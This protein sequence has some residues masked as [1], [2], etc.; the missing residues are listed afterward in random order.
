MI[1]VTK[2]D[3]FYT[4]S[5]VHSQ[6]SQDAIKDAVC[7]SIKGATASDKFPRQNIVPISGEMALYAR[8]LSCG[9]K[10]A[11]KRTTKAIKR[12]LEDYKEC[13]S[14]PEGENEVTTGSEKVLP[15]QWK[16]ADICLLEKASGI[17]MLEERSA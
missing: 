12:F 2:F 7:T 16:L 3:K 11:E 14:P 13:V 4:A 10:L 6:M 5:A 1:A 17:Q 15:N 9:E 8:K